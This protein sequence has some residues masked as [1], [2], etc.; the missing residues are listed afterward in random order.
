MTKIDEFALQFDEE[1]G[2]LDFGRVGPLARAV[3]EEE[4]AH[5]ELLRKARFGSLDSLHD[6]SEN[7]RFRRSV[8]ALT[9][10]DESQ[11]VFQPNTSLGLMQVMFGLRRGV[12]LS[13]MEFPSAAFAAVR[14]ADS[15]GVLTPHWLD[16]DYGRVTAGAV[17]QQLTDDI[18]AVAVSLV[19][20]RTG[21]LADLEGIRQVIGDRLLIV[22]AI[23]GFSVVDVDY[24]LADVVVSGGQKWARAGWGTGFLA[25]SERAIDHVSPVLSGF[26]G[27]DEGPIPLGSVPPPTRGVN[28][29]QVTNASPLAQSQFAAALEQIADVGVAAI[30]ERVRENSSRVIA[31][32]DEFGVPVSSPRDDR[33]RAGIVVLE[34]ALD[35]LTA[36][37]AAMHNHGLT[38][39]VR[40]VNV[41]VSVHASTTAETFTMLNAALQAFTATTKH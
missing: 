1:P 38:V 14:A 20:F 34:P 37:T 21:Y 3:V 32:A 12:L 16:A 33:E 19:D 4:V 39:T 23:Q 22:D 35:H 11:I 18:S 9:G 10:F 13:S 31:L 27:T 28:A 8:S 2:Y 17:K 40:D 7:R 5:L 15:L 41:R 26:N 24:S 29:F 25:M 6:G 30:A 36:L